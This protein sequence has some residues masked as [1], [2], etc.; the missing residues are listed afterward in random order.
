MAHKTLTTFIKSFS[1]L[2]LSILP[3]NIFSCGWS[4]SYETTRLALFRAELPSFRKLDKYVYS[5]DL[6]METGRV[7]N[8]DQLKNCQEWINK[9]DAKINIDDV[10]QILYNTNSEYFQNAIDRKDD[11]I[12]NENSFISSLNLPQNKPFLEYVICAKKMEFTNE[13]DDKWESW[14]DDI[15]NNYDDIPHKS[16]IEKPFLDEIITK[17]TDLFLKQRYAFLSLRAYFYYKNQ[18]AVQQLYDDYFAKNNNSIIAEWAKYYTA[19][20]LSDNALRNY[21]LSQIISNSDDK[22]NACVLNFDTN[23]LNK[24]ENLAKNNTDLG[25]IKAIPLLRNPA[26]IIENLKEV[27]VLIPDNDLFYFL[28]QRE[29]NKI[30][31]WIFTPKYAGNNTMSNYYDEASKEKY[32]IA[33]AENEIKDFKYLLEFKNLLISLQPKALGQQKDFL[34]AA[35]AQLCFINNQISE[36]SNYTNLISSK[37]NP[38]IQTQKNVQLVLITL[39]QNDI[40]TDVT[41]EKLFTYFNEIENAVEKDNTLFKSLYTLSIIAS[42]NYF[43]KNDIATAGL[44]FMKANNKKNIAIGYNNDYYNLSPKNYYEYIGYYDRLATTKSIDDL[45]NIAQKSNK[46]NFEKYICSGNINPNINAYLDLKGTIAFRNN[47]LELAQ[48][49]F[50]KIPKDFWK[51]NYEFNIYLNE[52]PFFPKALN[53]ANENRKFDYDFNKADFVATLIKLRNTKTADSYLKLANAYFNVS[54]FGNSWMMTSYELSGG[55]YNDYIYGDSENN[56]KKFGLGN[57]LNLNLAKQYYQLALQKSV[58]KE[59]KAVCTLMI[60]ECDYYKFSGA[61]AHNYSDIPMKFILGIEIYNFNTIYKNTN[62]FKKYN[63]PLLEQ[64]LKS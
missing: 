41:K 38:S 24:T 59:Q 46:S 14:D 50:A 31:D 33:K 63:C 28:I 15:N 35:I 56:Q 6:L 20:S 27:S 7:S 19:M 17:Q 61:N 62:V 42:T 12:F 29:I 53:Y 1:L 49:T 57:Y 3:S 9:L 36:G 5:L 26:P 30:E 39:Q 11:T 47:N 32:E 52:N 48:E 58:N 16:E 51:T 44:L 18:I 23:S 40:K 2:I 21:Y 25:I 22:A 10:Y 8:L 55:S 37:A 13:T 4:E 34:S 54:S 60:F 43:E 45:M 64:F